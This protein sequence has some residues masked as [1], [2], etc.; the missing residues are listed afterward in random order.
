MLGQSVQEVVQ[1]GPGQYY[2]MQDYIQTQ[3]RVLTSDSLAR[4]VVRR[5]HL[6]QDREFWLS[7]PPDNVDAAAEA[8]VGGS[9]PAQSSTRS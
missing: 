7:T 1:V 5:L 6:D 3:R 2:A 9:P 4:H 8:F